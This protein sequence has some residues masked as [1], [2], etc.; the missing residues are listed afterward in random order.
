MFSAMIDPT[1]APATRRRATVLAA[2]GPDLIGRRVGL[3]AN[4]KRNAQQ[5]LDEVGALLVH[6]HGAAALVRRTKLSITE[7]VPPDMLADVVVACDVVVVGVGDCGSCS[8]SAVADG[9]ALEAAGIPAVVVCTD[10][11]GVTA[12]AMAALQGSPGY[13]YVRIPHPVASLGGAELR[14]RALA[15]LPEIVATLT[16]GHA[17]T[18]A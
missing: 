2:R 6:R 10:A 11:F 1:A 15:A 5:F 17:R 13:H 16:T 12:D 8:A 4:V 14:R 18:A 9:L 7:P 3:L